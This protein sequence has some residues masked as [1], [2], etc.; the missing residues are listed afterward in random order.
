M[1]LFLLL[2]CVAASLSVH[3]GRR[4]DNE[5]LFHVTPGNDVEVA[6]IKYL[7]SIMELDFWKPKYSHHVTPKSNVYFHADVEQSKVIAELL[8]KERIK[9][10]IIF[11]D[12][13][14]AIE[15]QFSKG[16]KNK[17]VLTR[18]REW[19]E[20]AMWAYSILL[21]YPSLASIVQIGNS[22]EGHPML[23]LKIGNQKSAKKG[24]FLEC[25]IHAREWISPAFCQWFVTEAI[26][27]YG[28][29]KEMTRLLDSLTF[30][31][32]PVLNIDGY[33]W[34]WTNDRMWRK[35]RAP[36][37]IDKCIGTD[38]N[39]NFNISWNGIDF[40]D[41]P[42]S[43]AYAGTAPES[44]PEIKALTAYIRENLQSLRSYISFHSFSQL[45][46][47]PYGYTEELP[48]NHE[49]LIQFVALLS[50]GLIT[51]ALS[52]HLYLSC[53]MKVIIIFCFLNMT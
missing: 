1:Q 35:N 28:K 10:K 22:Y 23:V 38:L 52:T 49:K 53:V 34:T 31:V 5:K 47:Y 40:N 29:D 7:G 51:K 9:Y 12:L 24:V 2:C 36:T 15:N 26:R 4:F 27:T 46:L 19:K 32:L 43:E 45:L 14:K 39:R 18:Y 17:K 33:I 11:H 20:I 37:P 16:S 41:E 50:I 42:C 6:F 48:P 3:H 8:E 21:N 44:A 30:H 25:G 13:Q